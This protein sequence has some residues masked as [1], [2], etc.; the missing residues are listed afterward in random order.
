MKTLKKKGRDVLPDLVDIQIKVE[1]LPPLSPVEKAKFDHSL[2]IE[3]L[4]FSSKL[5]GT[6]LTGKMIEDAIHGSRF[7]TSQK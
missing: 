1:K 5:E 3:Q 7:P 6:N 2:A 4:Y